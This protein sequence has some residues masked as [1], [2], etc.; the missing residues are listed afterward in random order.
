MAKKISLALDG[1]S[2]ERASKLAARLG[3]RLRSVKIHDLLDTF[4]LKAFSALKKRKCT[5]WIDYKIHDTPD[6]VASRIKALVKNGAKIITVHASGGVRMMRAAVKAA[7]S[8]AEIYAVTVLTSLD[9]REIARV[10]GNERSREQ[11]VHE[12]A[13]MA[14][15]AGVRTIV[16]S[17][18]EIAMLKRSPDLAGMR[19]DVPGTR[20]KGVALGEQKRTA[21]L[22]KALADGADELVVGSQVTK[23]VDPIKTF[24]AFETEVRNSTRG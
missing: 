10:Y 1:L 6:T 24:A 2:L 13:L 17:A 23:A 9:G 15:E 4:G 21:T 22:A 20:L 7:G 3:K 14:R 16:C 5:L 18:Q 11:I 19:L 8:R 12:L